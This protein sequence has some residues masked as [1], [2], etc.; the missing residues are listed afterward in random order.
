MNLMDKLYNRGFLSYPRTETTQFNPNI[1]LKNIV[2]DLEANQIFGSFAKRISS[3]EMWSSPDRGKNDDGTHP[4][5]H[6]VKNANR[7]QL[8]ESEWKI[9]EL[10]ARH[11]L[12]SISKDAVGTKT[13]VVVIVGE[14]EFSSKN[15][16]VE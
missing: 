15:I 10:L 14:E 2:V 1:N 16:T 6:P 8:S 13:K 3:G 12:A 4:P 11:F 9:Y 7:E 5:I